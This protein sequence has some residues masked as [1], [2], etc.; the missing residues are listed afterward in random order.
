[1]PKRDTASLNDDEIVSCD[2]PAEL[3]DVL[4]VNAKAVCEDDEN[5]KRAIFTY[6]VKVGAGD[7]DQKYAY[8]FSSKTVGGYEVLSASVNGGDQKILRRRRMLA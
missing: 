6:E 4:S 8:V 3:G 2:P 7:V 1:M 5:R